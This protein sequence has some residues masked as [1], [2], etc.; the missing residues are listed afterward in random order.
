MP[1]EVQDFGWVRLVRVEPISEAQGGGWDDT[2]KRRRYIGKT[3]RLVLEESEQKC[4]GARFL[5]FAVFTDELQGWLQ[6][7]F[8]DLEE[9]PDYLSFRTARSCYIFERL[10]RG[11]K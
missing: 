4:P 10:G 6:T 11:E 5:F 1:R 7:G 2:A 9:Q 3:G 8:G